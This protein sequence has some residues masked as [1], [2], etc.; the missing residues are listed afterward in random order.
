MAA[1]MSEGCQFG[2]GVHDSAAKVPHSTD[3]AATRVASSDRASSSV[4]LRRTN[5]RN[6][7]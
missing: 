4:T 6:V 1:Y 3:Q 5:G 7:K 2:P